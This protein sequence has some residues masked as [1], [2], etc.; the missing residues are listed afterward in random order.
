MSAETRATLEILISEVL[1][2][3]DEDDE[4][5]RALLK[6]WVDANGLHPE[7]VERLS[8]EEMSR[9]FGFLVPRAAA[10]A[11]PRLRCGCCGLCPWDYPTAGGT[12]VSPLCCNSHVTDMERR[13]ALS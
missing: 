5:V 11:R 7:L 10:P 13:Q 2:E 1:E 3:L 8:G 4:R 6:T 12:G 9:R